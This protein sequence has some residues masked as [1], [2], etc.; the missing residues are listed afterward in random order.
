MTS[1]VVIS[2]LVTRYSFGYSFSTWRFHLRGLRIRGAHDV[3]WTDEMT[4]RT[5]M[6]TDVKT[7]TAGTTIATAR[8]EAP[9]GAFTR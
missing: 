7:V 5:I 3:G 6:Q 2:A 8:T 1:G 4:M 9:L